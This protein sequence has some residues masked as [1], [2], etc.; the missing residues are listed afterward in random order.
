MQE[1]WNRLNLTTAELVNRIDRERTQRGPQA[2]GT[3]K[4]GGVTKT[5]INV[6]KL[7]RGLLRGLAEANG[8]PPDAI[9]PAGKPLDRAMA[10][11]LLEEIRQRQREF[12]D[13]DRVA[14]LVQLLVARR[15]SALDRFL[16]ARNRVV[17]EGQDVAAALRAMAEVQSVLRH[18]RQDMGWP[19]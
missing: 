17:H 12:S 10:K 8:M 16:E 13:D 5:S 2:S 11:E 14:R 3:E 6:E 9:R 18:F 19:T 1:P 15:P 7:L 4:V